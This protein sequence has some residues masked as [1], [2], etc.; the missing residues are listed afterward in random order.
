MRKNKKRKERYGK[1][2]HHGGG[3]A[4]TKVCTRCGREL[5]LESFNT[6][7]RYG[8]KHVCK[9]CEHEARSA[10]K[11]KNVRALERFHKDE[12]IKELKMRGIDVLVNPMPRDLML[13]LK[14]AGFVG[15][16]RFV[17]TKTVNLATLE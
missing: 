13:R 5:P 12:L 10:G 9:D 17:Q 16:L 4:M 14:E 15:E 7:K 2:K 11:R 1:E 6:N 3:D 8:V